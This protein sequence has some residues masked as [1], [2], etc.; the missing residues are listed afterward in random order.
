[1][2]KLK[3][4]GS[5]KSYLT[6]NTLLA[7]IIPMIIIASI[8]IP[9]TQRSLIGEDA[10]RSKMLAKSV[11]ES[12][13]NLL[14]QPVTILNN[15]YSQAIL[16]RYVRPKDINEY[17]QSIVENSPYIESIF[18]LDRNGCILNADTS[19]K[20]YLG[21]DMSNEIFFR[22]AAGKKSVLW[23]PAYYAVN[24]SG[25]TVSVTIPKDACYIV[26]VL[27]L[28]A[29][30]HYISDL[31]HEDRS[32]VEVIDQKGAYVAHPDTKRVTERQ[33]S[34]EYSAYLESLEKGSDT[35]EMK[36]DGREVAATVAE[37]DNPHWIVAVIR[38]KSEIMAPIYMISFIELFGLILAVIL[39]SLFIYGINKRW[40]SIFYDIKRKISR[41]V[42]EREALD[43]EHYKYEEMNEIAH[44]FGTAIEM[45]KE[46]E[47]ILKIKYDEEKELKRQA[48]QANLAKNQ[49]LAN[50]SHEIRT[51]MNGIMGMTDLTLMTDLNEEQRENL[52]L[53]KASTKALLRV[54]NDILDYSK[55]EAGKMELEK[56]L[57]HLEKT[58]HEVTD[59]FE[60]EAKKKKLYLR[61]DLEESLPEYFYGDFVRLKQILSNLV[62]NAVKFTE[63]GG[64]DIQVS[65]KS[66]EDRKVTL[67]FRVSDTGIGISPENR[68]KLFQ[69]FSQVDSSNT[70]KFGGSGLGL[71]I[72]KRLVELMDGEIW[73]ESR[74]NAGSS[75]F[76]TAVFERNA[77]EG[78]S[79]V[80]RP[81]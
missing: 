50:M 29:I 58:I 36:Y 9:M 51:P 24:T 45:V 52:T 65:G 62:G 18:I 66:L 14:E 21:M 33:Y 3:R 49:F 32:L 28:D 47:A 43:W 79:Q 56:H 10:E 73:V 2:R 12:I 15:V 23:S 75:F 77:G 22:Q 19:S 53:I 31:K 67:L 6:F 69:R 42:E 7:T 60:I 37:L 35:L 38:P 61:V 13:K 78:A 59:L 74:A 55:I 71:A 57:F 48:E 80:V 8:V 63:R 54:L 1:M 4:R 44:A 26:G 70:R 76:F 17:L 72:S 81:S 40:I 30:S 16:N 25:I 68:D 11:R 20:A 46:R 27:H 64:I 34:E 5:L 39:I 41:A